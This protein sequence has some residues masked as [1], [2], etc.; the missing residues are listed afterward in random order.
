MHWI[1]F[2]SLATALFY[3]LYLLFFR[4]DRW[5]Q[6]SRWYLMVTMAFSLVYPLLR[7]PEMD[8]LSLPMKGLMLPMMELSSV[9]PLAEPIAEVQEDTDPSGLNVGQLVAALYWAGVVMSFILL[10]ASV[11]RL[12]ARIRRLPCER[13]GRLRVSLLDDDT[14][15]YSFFTHIVVGTKGM[16]EEQLQCILS[17]EE[18]HVRERH[19]LD[20]LAMRLMCCVAW[21]NPLAWL[22]LYELRAVHEYLA[23]GAVL[24]MCGREGYLGLL[25]REATGIGYGHITNN[26]QSIHLKKRI[27][28]MNKTKTRFGAW[29]LMAALPVVALLL[30]LGCRPTEAMATESQQGHTLLNVTYNRTGGKQ[31]PL[32]GVG[33]NK[34]CSQLSQQDLSTIQVTCSGQGAIRS[35]GTWEI[36]D[37][38]TT[39]G[40]ING[41]VLS[42]YE[43]KLI[44]EVDKELR[45]GNVSGTVGRTVTVDVCKGVT[46]PLLFTATWENGSPNGDADITLRIS[47]ADE[48][49][50]CD[51]VKD[52]PEFVGGIDSLYRYLAENIHYP[53]QAKE[54][55]IQGRVYVRFV[56][57]ADG[58]VADVEVLR[59]IGGGCDEEAL[60]VVKAMPKWKPGTVD[61]KPVRMQYNLP[62][63]FRL[64]EK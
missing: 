36:S 43:R 3:G 32:G 49:G 54:E 57:E 26:F 35:Y 16:N 52:D 63:V 50:I 40:L 17:H 10:V 31:L 15:P 47:E 53:E 13:R 46:V 48:M 20:V 18:L 62:I 28:M 14:A 27:K 39:K 22:M 64:T 42:R 44:K 7:L 38:Q 29:K 4:R 33:Y 56:I 2:S 41:R 37:L 61:G 30:L 6:L 58:S 59:G 8:L 34:V 19:T 9:G 55:G 21:F 5:L 60:R 11:V 23:D 12:L 25:Y 1:L 51:V 45:K 24:T